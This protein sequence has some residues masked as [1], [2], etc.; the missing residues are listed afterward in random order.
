MTPGLL[1]L[2]FIALMTLVCALRPVIPD[3][4]F[5]TFGAVS[6]V[7]L[8]GL[9]SPTTLAVIGGVTVLWLFPLHR[10]TQELRTDETK[11]EMR[12]WVFIVGVVVLVGCMVGFKLYQRFAIPW[13]GEGLLSGRVQALVGF[14][15][16]LFR[17]INFLYIQH[18][19]DVGRVRLDE[20][21]FYSL[22]PPTLTSGPIHKFVDFRA[23]MRSPKKPEWKDYSEGLYRITRG[24]FRKLCVAMILYAI[25]GN[26]LGSEVPTLAISVGV[27]VALYLYFYFDFAGYSDVAIGFGRLLGVRVPENFRQ[28]FTAST[29]A[30]FWRH[31]HITL[32]DWLRDHVFIPLGGRT[33]SRQRAGALSLLVMTL[34][35]L[36]HG[37][38]PMWLAWGLWHGI[39]LAIEGLMGV[40]TTP[41]AHRSGARYWGKVAWTNLRVALGALLFLPETSDLV[42]VL[43]GFLP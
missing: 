26:L 3:R 17:A 5:A 36:W 18:L 10:L 9:A 2:R 22:F 14:S 7:L 32:V 25:V 1:D 4:R 19:T 43:S 13:M 40:R 29:L 38:T 27:T 16:F 28:P 6:S 12:R 24:Y 20:L 42:F 11:D 31:W 8:V 30:E 33:A 23:Q 39:H 37:L 41:P 21:L 35:G 15:Y 34:A